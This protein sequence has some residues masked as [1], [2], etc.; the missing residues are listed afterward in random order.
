MAKKFYGSEGVEA[1]LTPFG[2][3]IVIDVQPNKNIEPNRICLGEAE[4]EELWAW[5]C[6]NRHKNEDDK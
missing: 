5:F 3:V 4:M 6:E 1:E 2:S